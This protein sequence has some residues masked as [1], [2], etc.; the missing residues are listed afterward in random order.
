M[1]MA[2]KKHIQIR[3]W[4]GNWLKTGRERARKT[5]PEND[6]DSLSSTT[7]NEK[8]FHVYNHSPPVGADQRTQGYSFQ[9]V[10]KF[11]CAGWYIHMGEGS[12]FK[13]TS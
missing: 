1:S 12:P 4:S 13:G 6:L 8:T 7:E 2:N 9:A 3:P 5:F 10:L 11:E